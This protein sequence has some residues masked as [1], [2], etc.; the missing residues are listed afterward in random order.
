MSYRSTPAFAVG[1]VSWL[2]SEG[3]TSYVGDPT[4]PG[5]RCFHCNAHFT[6]P[7]AAWR[8]FGNPT[9]CLR[10]AKF[11]SVPQGW[12]DRAMQIEAAADGLVSA[13]CDAIQRAQEGSGRLYATNIIV[14]DERI[15]AVLEAINLP[16]PPF[17]KGKGGS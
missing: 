7:K 3:R 10:S 6:D 17:P 15:A 2:A 12:V 14:L 4:P 1:G 13:A 9:E 5:W 16:E 8:H 11:R